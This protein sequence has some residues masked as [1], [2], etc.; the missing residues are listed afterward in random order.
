MSENYLTPLM[1]GS[2][3]VKDHSGKGLAE[4]MLSCTRDFG[5]DDNQLEGIGVDGQYIHLGVK[6]HMLQ[7]MDVNYVSSPD[8]LD[9]WVTSIWEPSHS[10]N[11]GD[12]DI[13]EMQIFSWLKRTTSIVGSISSSLNIGKG[14]EQLQVT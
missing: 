7:L 13:R 2:P 14:L 6:K 12:H 1:L 11:L 5:I 3:I 10:I 9:K 4:G 8:G